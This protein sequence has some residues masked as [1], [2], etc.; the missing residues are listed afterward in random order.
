MSQPKLK[1][2]TN[3]VDPDADLMLRIW[4]GPIDE[5]R[6]A[7]AKR[8]EQRRAARKLLTSPPLERGGD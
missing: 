4:T 7:V 6:A 1:V 2:I 3:P 5:A 8:L